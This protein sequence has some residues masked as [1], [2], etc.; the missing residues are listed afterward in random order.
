VFGAPISGLANGHTAA[1]AEAADGL[2]GDEGGSLPG[3]ESSPGLGSVPGLRSRPGLYSSP[4]PAGPDTFAAEV[5]VPSV[6]PSEESR[7]PI[8]ESV[9]SDWFRRGRRQVSTGEVQAPG[10]GPEI[11]DAWSSVADE[12]WRAAQAAESPTSGGVTS[13][14]LPKRI[15]RA[16]LVPGGVATEAERMEPPGVA[17]SAAAT[18][19]RMTS[20][21]RGTRRGRAALG[22]EDASG[23]EDADAP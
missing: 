18:R 12:G 9:E 14:G 16:N 10:A 1:G 8:F 20:F 15:P 23:E 3:L 19:E 17:R 2:P 6:Q 5:K 7:L 11:A 4:G 21:Q 13:A 22:G